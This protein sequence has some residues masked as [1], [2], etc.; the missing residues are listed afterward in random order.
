MKE[1]DEPPLGDPY[2]GRRPELPRTQPVRRVPAKI[3]AQTAAVKRRGRRPKGGAQRPAPVS[4]RRQP[5][6]PAPAPF[7][8]ADFQPACRT[9]TWSPPTRPPPPGKEELAR[10]LAVEWR[11]SRMGRRWGARTGRRKRRVR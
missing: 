8:S 2:A 9:A 3:A 1:K 4:Q 11:S 7:A 5:A 10:E 6:L